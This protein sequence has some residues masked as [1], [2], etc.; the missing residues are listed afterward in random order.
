MSANATLYRNALVLAI[1]GVT[2]ALI[3]SDE[4]VARR[5]PYHEQG[6]FRGITVH[7]L[8]PGEAHGTDAREDI[9]YAFGISGYLGN[10]HSLIENTD[11]V[12]AVFEAI[13]KKIINRRT[14]ATLATGDT[15]LITQLTPGQLHLPKEEWRF[16]LSTMFVR[17]WA[18]E[19]RT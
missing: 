1:Q 7:D 3:D 19:S 8:E 13:R 6:V 9:G 17:C 11:T 15:N 5:R 2:S 16:E 14:A 18:R 12:A 10:D 4:I